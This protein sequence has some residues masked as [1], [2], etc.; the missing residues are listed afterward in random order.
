MSKFIG[1]AATFTDMIDS[2]QVCRFLSMVNSAS[3]HCLVTPGLQSEI[4]VETN[5]TS[6]I[7]MITTTQSSTSRIQMQ[8]NNERTFA[9]EDEVRFRATINTQNQQILYKVTHCSGVQESI[10]EKIELRELSV[11]ETD[12]H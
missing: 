11:V 1:R 7:P 4:T 6:L 9:S 12:R 5:P 10:A 2:V 3:L 8:R